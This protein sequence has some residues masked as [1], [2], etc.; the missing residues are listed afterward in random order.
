MLHDLRAFSDWYSFKKYWVKGAVAKM[1]C[2]IEFMKQVFPMLPKP[3]GLYPKPLDS[4]EIL[5]P[6]LLLAF[7]VIVL[8]FLESIFLE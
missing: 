2:K 7:V 5:D 1:H 3:T 8:Y 4:V 6:M